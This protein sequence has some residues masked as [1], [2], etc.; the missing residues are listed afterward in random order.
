MAVISREIVARG[1]DGEGPHFTRTN[2]QRGC[3]F[4]LAQDSYILGIRTG[5]PPRWPSPIPPG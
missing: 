2:F 5:T 4:A 1:R 3:T